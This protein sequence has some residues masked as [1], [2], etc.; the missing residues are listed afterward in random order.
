MALV[1]VIPMALMVVIPM[2]LMVVLPMVL[3]LV[4]MRWRTLRMLMRMQV[5]RVML[6]R[7]SRRLQGRLVRIELAWVGCLRIGIFV[8]LWRRMM[9]HGVRDWQ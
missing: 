3:V 5:V 7:G 4:L 8:W 6:R 9:F 2:A 1:V